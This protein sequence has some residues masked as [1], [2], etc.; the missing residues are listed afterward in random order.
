MLRRRVSLFG[1]VATPVSEFDGRRPPRF[2]TDGGPIEMSLALTLRRR[3]RGAV[4]VKA[5]LVTAEGEEVDPDGFSA[6]W[7]GRPVAMGVVVPTRGTETR[8]TLNATGLLLAAGTYRWE[9]E[10]DGHGTEA[11]PFEVRVVA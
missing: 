8:V 5:K 1:G 4:W 9:V 3:K 2:T 10:L 7:G 6:T 11:C